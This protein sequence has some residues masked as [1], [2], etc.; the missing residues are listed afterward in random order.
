MK[1]I[2][3][4]NKKYLQTYS[5]PSKSAIFSNPIRLNFETCMVFSVPVLNDGPLC[6]LSKTSNWPLSFYQFSSK[7]YAIPQFCL[8]SQ[9]GTGYSPLNIHEHSPRRFRG[10]YLLYI[11]AKLTSAVN[12]LYFAVYTKKMNLCLLK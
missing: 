10:D 5:P 8:Q 1:Q 11:R 3:I 12:I 6:I 9:I 7:S 2:V 4:I